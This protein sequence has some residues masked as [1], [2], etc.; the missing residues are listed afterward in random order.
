MKLKNKIILALTVILCLS[1]GIITGIWYHASNRLTEDYLSNVSESSV[2][3][4]YHAFE[5][6]L[7]DT[8]YMAAMISGNQKNIIKPVQELNTKKLKT[9]HQWNQVYLNN[10]RTILEYV[11]SIDGYKYYIAGISIAANEECIFSANHIVQQDK[12]LYQK[13]LLLDQDKMKR[14]IIMMEP[15]HMEGL[16]STVS[17]DYVV[18]AVRAIIDDQDEIIGYVIIYFDYG[19]I[20]QM[21]SA[22]L[23]QGSYFEVTNDQNAKIYASSEQPVAVNTAGYVSNTFYAENV[24]W[25]FRMSIPSQYYISGI[26][27]TT[28]LTG[29][30][31]V[32][33]ILFSSVMLALLV[34]NLTTE[35]TVLRDKMDEVSSGNLAVRYEVKQHDEIG[36]MGN[37]FNEMVMRISELMDKVALEEKQKRV[38]EM[39]FLQAQINPHFVSNVLNNVVWMAKIQHADNIVPLVNSLNYL[40]RAVIHQENEFICLKNELE[41]VDNYLVIMEY[42]GSYDFTVEREI[43]ERTLDFYIPRFIVQPIIEN[44]I[45]HGIQY[46]LSKQGMIRISSFVLNDHW[47]IWVE[48]NGNGMSQEEIDH[49][50]NNA[51]KNKKSF[52]GVGVANVNERIRMCFGPQYGLRYESEKGKFTKCIFRFPILTEVEIDG[53]DQTGYSR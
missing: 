28:L 5:Y 32:A 13:I 23:P 11:N 3:D 25:T 53:K 33:I 14:S 22:N 20:D 50:L 49:I 43:D 17:S 37:T 27:K 8:S 15:M 18:P 6:L 19:V 31:I 51:V 16:K 1:G 40:L 42:S 39:A 47:E 24:G 9:Y 45:C 46:D 29:L 35:I 2:K 30:A 26:Q 52:N 7:T 12:N 38:A 36:Q 4:A 48:D 21:F 10:R 34:S 44:A 41:Y